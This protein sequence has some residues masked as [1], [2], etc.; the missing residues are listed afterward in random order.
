MFAD[1]LSELIRKK[2]ITRYQVAKDTG[3][4]EATLSNYARR[5]GNPNP[6]IVKQ[7]ATYFEVEYEWL[8]FGDEDKADFNTTHLA[9]SDSEDQT[10]YYP[11][12]RK[13]K[14]S[15]VATSDLSILVAHFEKQLL[16]KDKMIYHLMSILDDKVDFL[17][18][19]KKQDSK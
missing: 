4:T 18:G 7:L 19:E 3:V 8:M 17:V 6:S 10:S 11:K 14:E 16:A 12:Q 15:T 5:K 13:K 1:R 2:Q 9:D